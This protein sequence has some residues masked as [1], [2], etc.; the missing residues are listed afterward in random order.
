MYG[1]KVIIRLPS[2]CLIKLHVTKEKNKQQF[3]G[4]AQK[5][6]RWVTQTI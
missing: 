4:W 1:V 3:A 5:A 6:V 2:R